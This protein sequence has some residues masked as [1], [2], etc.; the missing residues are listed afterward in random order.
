[1]Q[2]ETSFLQ[3]LT[4]GNTG[5]PVPELGIG[6]IPLTRV[7]AAEAKGLIEHCLE[8]GIRFFDTAHVYL[9]SEEK[10][11]RALEAFRS[12]VVIATKVMATDAEEAAT[13][14]ELSFERLRT[15][16]IDLI[17]CHNLS[18]EEELQQVLAPG[19]AYEALAAA[20]EEGRVGA[21]GFSSHNPNVAIQ[22]CR[23]GRFA[24][25]QFPFNFIENDPVHTV[26]PAAREQG[27]GIIAM[28]PLGGGLLER[29]DLCFRFLQQHPGI[30]P[31]PGI[32]SIEEIDEIAGLYQDRRPLSLQDQED[33][34]IFRNELGGRFCHR[35]EYC[36]P[37]EQGVEIPRAL[38]IQAQVRRFPRGQ[39]ITL[40]REA[41]ET[42]ERCIACGECV[43]R[44]PYDLPIPEMLQENAAVYR[45]V[46]NSP[47]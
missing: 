13:Q 26:F 43:E 21:I 10:L 22:A 39:V 41:I 4:L 28:K 38:L 9:D 37:C 1:M 33:M 24:T 25:L 46:A 16:R 11:G 31:I 17:Q 45:V 12:E 3:P 40:A 20:Q 36:M 2:R 29:A 35:C 34:Q 30:L 14:L 44:C 42:V 47:D 18:K 27:M 19:G 8:L 6:G 7:G 15:D 23:T 32:Q 5:L